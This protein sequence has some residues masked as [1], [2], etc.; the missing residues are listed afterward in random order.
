MT[1]Q[2][3]VITDKAKNITPPAAPEHQL[4]PKDVTTAIIEM[5]DSQFY[6]IV[7]VRLNIPLSKDVIQQSSITDGEDREYCTI[8]YLVDSLLLK[9]AATREFVVTSDGR[10]VTVRK[11]YHRALRLWRSIPVAKPVPE[12]IVNLVDLTPRIAIE[13]KTLDKSDCNYVIKQAVGRIF[14]NI[15]FKSYHMN[16]ARRLKVRLDR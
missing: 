3:N 10:G 11:Y 8:E 4:L 5:P 9:L 15:H 16:I 1:T 13:L 2:L 12:Y 7:A 14:E 6:E